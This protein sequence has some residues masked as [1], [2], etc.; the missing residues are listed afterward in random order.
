M[1][2]SAWLHA[3]QLAQEAL[4]I[5][6]PARHIVHMSSQRHAG[7]VAVEN[8]WEDAIWQ[9]RRDEQWVAL[10]RPDDHV[11]QFAGVGTILGKLEELL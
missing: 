3:G 7:I 11:T 9:R 5:C 6:R 8:R 2:V 1:L 10:E 4:C